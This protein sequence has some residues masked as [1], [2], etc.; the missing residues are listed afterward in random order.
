M[1]RICHY[2]AAAVV[3]VVTDPGP[4]CSARPLVRRRCAWRCSHQRCRPHSTYG[5]P[6]HPQRRR[7]EAAKQ[8]L[9]TLASSNSCSSSCICCPTPVD[10][11]TCSSHRSVRIQR[12]R[13]WRSRASTQR[14]HQRH[15]VHECRVVEGPFLTHWS[16]GNLPP[17][18]CP[19]DRECSAAVCTH[20][21]RQ[22]AS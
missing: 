21:L 16:R 2:T 9:P 11:P 3:A 10:A 18:V 4:N 7:E 6:E 22:H 5:Q 8:L 14:P 19:R 15:G 17:L 13:P 20:Q 12:N 1:R